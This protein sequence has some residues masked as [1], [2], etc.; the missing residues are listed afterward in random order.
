[1]PK[2]TTRYWNRLHPDNGADWQTVAGLVG[3]AEELTLNMD[4]ESSEYTGLTRFSPGADTTL[5][6]GK[7]HVYPEEV[8]VV[9]SWIFDGAFQIWLQTG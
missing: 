7:S 9:S 1:M 5:F 4:T 8:F 3:M 6:G 2:T